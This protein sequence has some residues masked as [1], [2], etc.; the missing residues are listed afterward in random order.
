MNQDDES[1][2]FKP[3]EV[4]SL[5]IPFLFPFMLCLIFFFSLRLFVKPMDSSL[6]PCLDPGW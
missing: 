1:E 6:L 4:C 2:M 3:H 5:T